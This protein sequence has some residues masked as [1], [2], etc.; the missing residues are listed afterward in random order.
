MTERFELDSRPGDRSWF[1]PRESP[2]PPVH[3]GG[4]RPTSATA[5]LLLEEQLVLALMKADGSLPRGNNWLS[6][7]VVGAGLL[8]LLRHGLVWLEPSN[9]RLSP[10]E[11]GD[12][13]LVAGGAEA[14]TLLGNHILGAMRRGSGAASLG[15]WTATLTAESSMV[16][17]VLD[18]LAARGV[19][20]KQQTRRFGMVTMNRWRLVD[21]GARAELR[22]ELLRSVDKG[23]S[24]GAGVCDMYALGCASEAFRMLFSLEQWPDVVKSATAGANNG[25]FETLVIAAVAANV[26]ADDRTTFVTLGRALLTVLGGSSDD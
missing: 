25:G 12:Q 4:G 15:S 21:A 26:T 17:V 16:H 10:W 3:P 14:E 9:G 24:P 2:S 23:W 11:K 19:I 8:G 18:S 20:A 5:S 6:L 7:A 13:V 1:E 22:R